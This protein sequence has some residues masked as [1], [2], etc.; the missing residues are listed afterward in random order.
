MNP[1]QELEARLRADPDNVSLAGEL[2]TALGEFL[3]Y[4]PE[5]RSAHVEYLCVM[6]RRARTLAS[7]AELLRD[8]SSVR[9]VL[10]RAALRVVN[11]EEVT[12]AALHLVT[13]GLCPWVENLPRMIDGKAQTLVVSIPAAWLIATHAALAQKQPRRP[14][15]GDT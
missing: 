14:R 2:W 9:S 11:L 4:S 15:R 7:A 1:L 6:S 10:I 13:H 3:G 8:G 5:E 12:G